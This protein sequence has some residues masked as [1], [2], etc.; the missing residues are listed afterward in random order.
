L[1]AATAL[2]VQCSDDFIDLPLEGSLNLE[3][4]FNTEADAVLLVNGCYDVMQ[5]SWSME[6]PRML[7]DLCA[8]NAWKGGDSPG[9]QGELLE[10]MYFT[11]GTTNKF[12]EYAWKQH[13]IGVYRCNLAIEKI[14]GIKTMDETLRKRLI[15]EAKFLRAYYYFELVKNFGDLPIIK[16]PIAPD[17][18][19]QPRAP[20]KDVYEMLIEP[21]LLEVAELLPQK[22]VYSSSDVGRVTRG[23]ALSLLAKT[24]LYEKKWDKAFNTAQIVIGEGKYGLEPNFRRIFDIENPNGIESIFEVQNSGNQTNGEGAGLPVA[25]RS[26][27]DGGWGWFVPSTNLLMAFESGDPRKNLTIVSHGD[28]TVEDKLGIPYSITASASNQAPYRMN[29]KMY[30]P[31]A[32][33]VANEWEH[34]A[35][36]YKLIR[37]ADLLLMYAEAA[38]ES[39]KTAEAVN[40]LELV[41][42][43]ARSMSSDPIILP[44]VTTTD[45]VQVRNAIRQER[46]VEFAM[47]FQRFYDIVRWG[48][49]KEALDGFADFNMNSSLTSAQLPE[50]GDSKG[51]LFKVGKHELFAVPARDCQLAGWAQNPG[52]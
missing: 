31:V 12:V 23:A 9:D 28:L 40:T 14:P 50:K 30:I 5:A 44:Q 38:N 26:R 51:S 43:R 1:V 19:N 47:E 42:K 52:Y 22:D 36:N 20:K 29:Y 27:N 34:T 15:A 48:I 21:D 8:D 37:Y 3:T 4:A 35:Y 49:A 16:A 17:A 7:G 45:Q 41:R 33:R 13:W 18:F 11:A 10:L 6:V 25:C 2:F 39:G 32:K 24:Y 46:R